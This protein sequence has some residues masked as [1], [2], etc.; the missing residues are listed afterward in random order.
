M[1]E[2]SI[3]PKEV[4][5]SHFATN[6]LA[7][8]TL[9]VRVWSSNG[10]WWFILFS[11]AVETTAKLKCL[12]HEWLLHKLRAMGLLTE[13]MQVTWY[14]D[15]GPNQRCNEVITHAGVSL[16]ELFKIHIMV[17]VALECHGKCRLDGEMG[18]MVQVRD[19]AA[20]NVVIE[21]I[22]QMCSIHDAH[23]NRLKRL[24]PTMDDKFLHWLDA[25]HPP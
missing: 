3:G 16:G 22:D 14:V 4:G 17:L 12:Q 25:R 18:E 23:H 5:A 10:S 8:S 24:D 21:S 9:V 15:V 19:L 2:S 13:W 6:K 20:T 7:Y 1:F 11:R